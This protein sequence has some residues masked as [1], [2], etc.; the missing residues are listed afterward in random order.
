MGLTKT[1]TKSRDRIDHSR[2]TTAGLLSRTATRVRHGSRR[3]SRVIDH[4][5]PRAADTLEK[6]AER[7]SRDDRSF[8][9]R[10]PARLLLLFGVLAAVLAVFMVKR[11]PGHR[12]DA[13][14]EDF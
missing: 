10:S 9:R 13:D 12:D 3:A 5:G 14:D 11:T 4:G 2:D 7:M 1:L 6:T 8:V